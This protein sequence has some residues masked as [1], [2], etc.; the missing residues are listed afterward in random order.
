MT[1]GKQLEPGERGVITAYPVRG[2][3]ATSFEAKTRV[4]LW[5]GDIMRLSRRASTEAEARAKVR[6][7]ARRAI[8]DSVRDAQR[9]NSTAKPSGPK[10]RE[11]SPGQRGAIAVKKVVDEGRVRFLATV[12]VRLRNGDL[13]TVSRSASTSGLAKSAAHD[14]AERRIADSEP[15][16]MPAQDITLADIVRMALKEREARA[17]ESKGGIQPKT[18]A[19]YGI[20]LKP[21]LKAHGAKSIVQTSGALFDMIETTYSWRRSQIKPAFTILRSAYDWAIR[22]ERVH[23]NPMNELKRPRAAAPAPH[24]LFPEEVPLVLEA[25]RNHHN[26]TSEST[27]TLYSDLAQLQYTIGARSGELCALRWKD[28]TD[29]GDKVVLQIRG[30]IVD[31]YSNIAKYRK[32]FTKNEHN[33]ILALHDDNPRHAAALEVIRRRATAGDP[34]DAPVFPA[35]NGGWLTSAVVSQRWRTLGIKEIVGRPNVTPHALRHTYVTERFEEGWDHQDTALRVGH[36]DPGVTLRIYTTL[37][38]RELGA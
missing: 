8:N 38:P 32:P 11:L 6:K 9:A 2:L 24:A 16:K 23:S 31:R 33:R 18:V 21:F 19:V 12:T 36:R 5:N 15:S 1:S 14:E 3:N 7:A 28:V 26:G 20:S 27:P 25:L 4:R 34:E 37:R 17:D 35:A 30:T 29:H 10:P 22:K 13:I